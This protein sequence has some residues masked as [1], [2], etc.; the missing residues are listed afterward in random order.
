M[1]GQL[2]IH[3]RLTAGEQ[4]DI[5]EAVAEA[6]GRQSRHRRTHSQED[7]GVSS[8]PRVSATYSQAHALA[9]RHPLRSIS[10]MDPSI[11]AMAHMQEY[12]GKPLSPGKSGTG[13]HR[14]TISGVSKGSGTDSSDRSSSPLTI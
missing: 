11:A 6:A 3:A 13:S 7:A 8:M 10:S 1:S 12:A 4:Q 2:D 9:A 5:A 14:S